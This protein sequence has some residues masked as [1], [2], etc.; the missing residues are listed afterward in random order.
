MSASS[1]HDE[2]RSA[3]VALIGRP[4]SGKSTLINAVLEENLSI[5]T[6]LPQTTRRNLRGIYTSG[7]TQLVFV[8]TPGIHMGKHALNKTISEHGMRLLEKRDCDLICYIVDLSRE[9]G[10]EEDMIAE[11]VRQSA[12]PV[13]VVF[14]KKDLCKAPREKIG[15]FHDRYRELTAGQEVCLSAT[16][17]E[18]RGQFL[19][20]LAPLIP[21]GPHYYPADD[22]TDVDLRFFA[23]E[24]IRAALIAVSR[25]EVPH[26]AFVEVLAYREEARQH[27]V[28]AAIHVETQGQKGIV[29]GKR[30][31]VIRSIQSRAERMLS[32]LIG[33]PASIACHVKV[34]PKWR[35]NKRFLADMGMSPS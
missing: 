2:S 10:R 35:D 34:T 19:A 31:A 8:D 20:A 26:A 25:E 12:L 18:A 4:N 33:A 16:A 22:L 11:L 23:A 9:L 29:I 21:A 7:Q 3:F 30:G 1:N 6:P 13:C 28:E 27:A 15:V 17:P 24:Y 32:D 14:N 5:V